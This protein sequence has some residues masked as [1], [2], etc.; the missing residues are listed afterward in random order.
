[1]RTIVRCGIHQHYRAR[2]RVDSPAE[3]TNGFEG[4]RFAD[5]A[6]FF[7]LFR[8]TPNTVTCFSQ[9]VNQSAQG[10]DKVNAIINC[11]LATGRIGRRGQGPFSLTGQPNA[12]GGREVGGLANQLAAHMAFT[13]EDIDRVR[14]FWNAPRVAAREGAKAVQ[15]F[16]AIARGRIK[17]LWV[18]ATNPTVSLP[19]ASHVREALKKLDLFVVSENVLANDTMNAG[20][21]ILLPAAAWGE[22]DGTVTNSERRISRQRRFLPAAGEAQPDWWIVTQVARRMGFAAAFAYGRAADIFREHAA[23]STFENGGRRDFDIGALAAIGDDAFDALDPV[24]WPLR[25]GE[26][27]Q[28]KDR[29]FFMRGGFYTADRKARFIAVEPPAPKVATSKE[30]PFRLNTGRLRDQWHTMTRSGQSARLGAHMPEPFVEVHPV[31]AKA[32]NLSDGGFAKVATRWGSCVLKVTVTDR[33]QAGSLFAPIHWSNATASAARI[34][35]LVMPET[36]RYSGQPDAK[37]TPA[38]IAPAAFAFRGFALTRRPIRAPAGTWWARVAVTRAS[39]LLLATNDGPEIWRGHARQ[40]FCDGAELAEYVDLQRGIYRTAAFVA[41]ELTGSLFIGPAG[42]APQWDAV[43]ALFEVETLAEEAR[44]VLLSGRSADGLTSTGP[45]VCHHPRRDRNRRGRER[46]GHRRGATRRHQLRLVPAR[47]QAH[48]RRCGRRRGRGII[49]SDVNRR[50]GAPSA[51]DVL[52][53]R[54]HKSGRVGSGNRAISF[55]HVADRAPS[56]AA[57][58][59][60]NMYSDHCA[61]ISSDCSTFG[62]CV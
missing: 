59:E 14:R 4:Q 32:M 20:A 28:H 37:A 23:L 19:R 57:G 50:P 25:A 29:R 22:K 35:D 1:M 46:R 18:M 6:R 60:A 2:I 58:S 54:I 26:T 9:G 5:V 39:G 53:P 34:C 44:R 45:I 30:F 52:R 13:S 27:V 62:S 56:R 55:E 43:K 16:D 8:S 47:A 31:D 17:A 38:S 3:R 40:M 12:M 49:A 10:T 61:A 24:Q 51:G 7:D 11:H 48:R 41:G 21:H 33:Q 36:D 15:M 42:A